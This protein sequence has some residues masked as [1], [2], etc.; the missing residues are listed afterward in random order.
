MGASFC[1]EPAHGETDPGLGGGREPFPVARQPT[2]AAEPSQRA[3]NHPSAGQDA[4]AGGHVGRLLVGADP[5]PTARP[6]HDPQLPA[7]VRAEP[8]CQALV[9]HVAEQADDVR[10]GRVQAG[11][12]DLGRPPVMP[13]S[14]VNAGVQHQPLA[15]HHEGALAARHALATVVAP[16]ATG[17]ADAGGLAVDDGRVRRPGTAQQRAGS[18]AQRRVDP[19]PDTRLPPAPELVADAAPGRDLMRQQAPGH[20]A[21]QHGQHRVDNDPPIVPTGSTTPGGRLQQRC[22]DRPFGVAEVGVIRLSTHPTQLP[23]NANCPDTL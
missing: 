8:G 3:L 4:E 15:V 6:L 20:A 1:H 22:Q 16:L 5:G 23:R 2:S 18:A 11:Q 19:A 9:G 10:M 7:Q 13:V 12:D 21:A 14:P 17:L